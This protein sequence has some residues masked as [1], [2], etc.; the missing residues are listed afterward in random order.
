MPF[1]VLPSRLDGPKLLQPTVFPDE[2]GFFCETYRENQLAEHGIDDAFVQDNHSR[3]SY[4]VIRGMHFQI[5]A[6]CG[7]LVRCGRGT[8]VDVV[9]DLR[10]SS[11]TYG[12]WEA[13]EL[14]DETMRALY[15]PVGF[16][17]GFAVTSEVA[18]VLYKQSAYYSA[19]VERGISFLDPA[20][21]IDWPIPQADR[22]FSERDAD[23][24]TL[25]QFAASGELPDW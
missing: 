12:E 13:F 9:V 24:M 11:S 16:G 23:A 1:E 10:R 20:V 18:D 4:G 19:E 7:K 3:S 6:G 8:I 17:H 25:E 22:I 5:G 14:S 15:V 2:R 21:G